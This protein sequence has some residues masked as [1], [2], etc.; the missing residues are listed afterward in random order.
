MEHEVQPGTYLVEHRVKLVADGGNAAFVKRISE[1]ARLY[2]R[3]LLTAQE[4]TNVAI[5][6]LRKIV[7]ID[8]VT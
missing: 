5:E 3:G 6:D 7:E 8:P 1:C 4:F 2:L